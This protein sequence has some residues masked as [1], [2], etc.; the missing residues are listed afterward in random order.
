[1]RYMNRADVVPSAKCDNCDYEP[2]TC[3]AIGDTRKL[4]CLSCCKQAV[5]VLSLPEFFPSQ[6]MAYKPLPAPVVHPIHVT[7]P[8]QKA[9]HAKQTERNLELLTFV[10]LV[11]TANEAAR[12]AGL[13]PV[14]WRKMLDEVEEAKKPPDDV[15]LP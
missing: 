14:D 7:T 4:I 3:I 10:G 6:P 15:H 9:A 12:A 2:I 13:P 5:D 11:I 8:E 1:M